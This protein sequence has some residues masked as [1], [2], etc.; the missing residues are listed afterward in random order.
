MNVLAT[1]DARISEAPFSVA[2]MLRTQGEPFRWEI[3]RSVWAGFSKA[4]L[5]EHVSIDPEKILCLKA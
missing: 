4:G 5:P 3:D 1:A 2:V